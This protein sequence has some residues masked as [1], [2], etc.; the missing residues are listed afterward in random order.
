MVHI[1]KKYL[2]NKEI[3]VLVRDAG[4]SRTPSVGRWLP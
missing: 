2:K 1:K 4:D 3:R